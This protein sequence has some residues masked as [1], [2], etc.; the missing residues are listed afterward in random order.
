LGLCAAEEHSIKAWDRCLEDT[1]CKSEEGGEGG[2][3]D[4]DLGCTRDVLSKQLLVG[5][6]ATEWGYC[7]QLSN[8]VKP[9]CRCNHDNE[10]ISSLC[11]EESVFG[12]LAGVASKKACLQDG[13]EDGDEGCKKDDQC[14]SNVCKNLLGVGSHLGMDGTCAKGPGECKKHLPG[15]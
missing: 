3:T 10:C 6:G 5:P 12:N 1:A 13:I 14:T 8:T 7:D 4:T 11:Q 2:I 15:K 9:R